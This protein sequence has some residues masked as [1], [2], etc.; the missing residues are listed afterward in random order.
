MDMMRLK[1]DHFKNITRTLYKNATRHEETHTMDEMAELSGP[2]SGKL[3]YRKGWLTIRRKQSANCVADYYAELEQRK[4]CTSEGCE[5][6]SATYED[7]IHTE[8][9]TAGKR[10]RIP[11]PLRNRRNRQTHTARIRNPE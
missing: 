8:I 7:M 10:E 4:I 5:Q 9:A 1:Y 3:S 2:T 6:V 11:Q